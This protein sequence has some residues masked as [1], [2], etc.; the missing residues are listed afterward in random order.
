M[1]KAES[2]NAGFVSLHR[3]IRDHW[4]WDDPIKLKWWLDILMECN[5]SEQ[6]VSIGFDLITCKRGESLN[7]LLTW[8]K[9]WRVDVST[10]RRF[11]KLLENDKMIVTK[12][13]QKTTRLT[14]CN[15]DTYNTPSTGKTIPKQSKSNPDAIRSQLGSNSDA[16]QTIMN[17]NDNNVNNEEQ[18][19]S[20]FSSEQIDEYK[21]FMDW[22]ERNAPRVNKLKEPITIKNF[23]ELKKRG[24]GAKFRDVLT[25]MH[26]Y[27]KLLSNNVSAYLTLINWLKKDH[28][29][30]H[31]NGSKSG[32][33][34]ANA[35][36]FLDKAKANYRAV[37]GTD[38]DS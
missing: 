27:K 24:D 14:V 12:N 37:T 36:S 22:I 33:K 2:K 29:G 25:R 1:A 35:Q 10:V 20:D 3:S 26:N 23:F 19:F 38:G 9:M 15:Y 21:K 8:G 28:D 17:N 32:S 11:F 7:S 30:T 4:I 13:V 5:H 16:I 6:K 34:S 31:I 18:C